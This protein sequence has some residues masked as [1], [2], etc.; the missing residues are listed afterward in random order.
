MTIYSNLKLILPRGLTF[1]LSGII[2]TLTLNHAQLPLNFTSKIWHN[3][4]SSTCILTSNLGLG[5]RLV[6][7]GW[8]L[9]GRLQ[10]A[11]LGFLHVDGS[12]VRKGKGGEGGLGFWTSGL[13]VVLGAQAWSDD[14]GAHESQAIKER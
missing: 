2:E 14:V 8:V 7:L 3:R 5:K 13:R 4:V 11:V 12:W 1:L 9:F 10:G 6:I